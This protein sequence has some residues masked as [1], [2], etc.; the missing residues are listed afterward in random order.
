MMEQDNLE[1]S[2]EFI[3]HN[4]ID[5]NYRLTEEYFND[6]NFKTEGNFFQL[7]FKQGSKLKNGLVLNPLKWKSHF[8]ITLDDNYVTIKGVVDPSNQFV[9]QTEID[10]WNKFIINYKNS[11]LQRKNL[12]AL[13]KAFV[14]SSKKSTFKYIG[15]GILLTVLLLIIIGSTADYFNLRLNQ[16]IIPTS[17]ITA[18]V[19]YLIQRK[20]NQ[21]RIN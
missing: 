17:A 18:I 16:M 14:K 19:I 8:Q 13:N 4:S 12:Y 5:L 10:C 1:F 20:M 2:L 21:N 15:Y 11:L 6:G 3:T 7:E 9:S